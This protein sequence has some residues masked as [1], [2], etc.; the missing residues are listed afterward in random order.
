MST[1]WQ[2]TNVEKPARRVRPS[3]VRQT[4]EEVPDRG[5]AMQ[6]GAMAG[7]AGGLVLALFMLAVSLIQGQDIWVGVKAAGFPFLGETALQPGF[8]LGPVLVGLITHF[9]VSAMW[10][11]IFG[12]LFAGSS[13]SATIAWGAIWG[14]IVWLAMSRVVLPVV[15]AGPIASSMGA[16]VSVF[17]HLLFGLALALAF[18]PYQRQAWEQ[19]LFVEPSRRRPRRR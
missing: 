6:A 9:A 19:A 2:V 12:G 13:P 16:A 4:P 17:E 11:A 14:L 1:T 5:P 18:L 8:A 10:G 3:V 7:L 15:G